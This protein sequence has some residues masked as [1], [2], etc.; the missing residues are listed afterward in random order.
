MS[1]RT[2]RSKLKLQKKSKTARSEFG[3]SNAVTVKKSVNA[4]KN[5]DLDHGK[6]PAAEA[7]V[8]G[9]TSKKAPPPDCY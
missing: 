1:S 8:T 3:K 9:T 5:T 2:T 4:D 6:T 7:N